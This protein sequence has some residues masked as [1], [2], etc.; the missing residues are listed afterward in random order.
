VSAT[1]PLLSELEAGDVILVKAS[2]AEHLEDLAKEIEDRW[3]VLQ[4]EKDEGENA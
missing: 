3:S 2:R 1:L 4:S